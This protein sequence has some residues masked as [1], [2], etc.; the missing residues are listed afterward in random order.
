MK[1]K[2]CVATRI[3]NVD[4]NKAKALVDKGKYISVSDLLRQALREK[5]EKEAASC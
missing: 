5:L 2:P 3:P 4:Y 1:S